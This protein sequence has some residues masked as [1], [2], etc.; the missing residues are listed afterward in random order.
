[1]GRIGATE[2][3]L[4]LLVALLL[5][6]PK[7]LADLGKSLGEG[8]RNFKKGLDPDDAPK[9]PAPPPP[10]ATP[11]TAAP[12]T[13]TPPTATPPGAGAASTPQ[14]NDQASR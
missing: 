6:G 4:I 11:P 12:P 10:T 14:A 3:L 5:F 9:P 1:M 8:L 7:K 2:L 13:A